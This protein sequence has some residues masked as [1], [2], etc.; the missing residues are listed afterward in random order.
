MNI[1]TAPLLLLALVPA[2]DT[3]KPKF[4]LGKE[5][6]HVTGPLDKDGY[7]DYTAALNERLGKGVTPE[8]NAVALL[9][10][11]LGPNPDTKKEVPDEYFKLLGIEKPPKEGD[12]FVN[13]SQFRKQYLKLSPSDSDE[14]W[15]KF[16]DQKTWARKRPWASVDYPDIATWLLVNEKPFNILVEALKRPTFFDPIFALP[17]EGKRSALVNAFYRPH[18]MQFREVDALLTARAMLRLREGK[19]DEAWQDLLACHRLGR[20][21]SQGPTL[22]DALSGYA[23]DQIPREA[24]L[25]YLER[26][27]FSPRQLQDRMKELLSLPALLDPSDKFDFAERLTHLDLLQ[28]I[29]DGEL[30]P[31]QHYGSGWLGLPKLGVEIPKKLV[32]KAKQ[33]LAKVDWEPGLRSANVW[34]DRV[35]IA[36]RVEDRAKRHQ[37]F[38]RLE[39]E[40][41]S[42]NTKAEKKDFLRK[43][44][45]GK[46]QPDKSAGEAISNIFLLFLPGGSEKVVEGHE[47]NLQTQRNLLVAFALAAHYRDRGRYPANLEDLAPKYL[48]TVPGDIFSGKP[49]IY[50]PGD[51]GYLFYSVGVNGKDDGGKGF[52]DELGC[53]DL[54]VRMP[55]PVLK[56]R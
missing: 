6:T 1:S 51:N 26:A 36:A 37:E 16:Y 25:S 46:D 2:Q 31:F 17:L 39:E 49:L 38:Q 20:F 45:L 11:A 47:R 35:V 53:D 29:C 42:L 43:L 28:R 54:S 15:L 50:R 13:E 9:W 40:L 18:H 4:P 27:N 56:R 41:K 5:T 44:L 7:I 12:Y 33:A 3:P 14:R 22:L 48:N 21:I 52:D 55:L 32:P 8:K 24:D 10:K 23:I 19:S 30:A 34:F